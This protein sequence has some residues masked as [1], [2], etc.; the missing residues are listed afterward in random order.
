MKI[1]LDIGH[2]T[3]TGSAS[4][5]VDEHE[6]CSA[7]AS[8]LAEQLKAQ[9]DVKIFDFPHLSNTADLAATVKTINA[10]EFDLI[11]SLHCDY[12]DNAGAGGAHVCYYSQTGKKYAAAIARHLC[13]I[14]PG[15]AEKIVRRPGL[16]VLNA[17]EDPAVLI[18]FGFVSNAA[19]AKK[20]GARAD[21]LASAVVAGI[22]SV[23]T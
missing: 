4:N 14:M 11:I 5:G 6:Y 15:R 21:Q 7:M 17:T 22:N 18:E 10:G 19:D 2:A 20:M 16:Y 23:A 9:H 13:H 1:A 12:S 3:G 8:I